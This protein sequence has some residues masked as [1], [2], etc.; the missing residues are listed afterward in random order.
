MYMKTETGCPAKVWAPFVLGRRAGVG[1]LRDSHA[2]CFPVPGCRISLQK[3]LV[4]WGVFLTPLPRG[5]GFT[6]PGESNNCFVTPKLEV[7]AIH[8]A[9]ASAQSHSVSQG[10]I[11]T[12][13]LASYLNHFRSTTQKQTT[14]T[15]AKP[16]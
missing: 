3:V 6:S 2:P 1:S 10:D 12:H 15:T 16:T 5:F 13:T 14:G 4:E 8:H 9:L 7:P 11:G